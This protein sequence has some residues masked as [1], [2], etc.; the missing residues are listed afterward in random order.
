M[1][2]APPLTLLLQGSALPPALSPARADSL[3]ATIDSVFAAPAYRWEA[4]EDPFGALRRLWGGLLRWVDELQR[5]NPATFNAVVWALVGVLALILAHAGWVALRTLRHGS[6]QAQRETAGP[7]SAP[8][9]ATWY[10]RESA[11]LAALGD[12]A[13]AMQAEFLRL[14][15]ELDARQVMRFHPSKTPNEYVRDASLTEDGR[16]DMRGLVREMYHYAF[17]RAPLDGLAFDR[18]RALAVA[19]R[20]RR[21]T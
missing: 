8:R 9:D 15:L 6:R 12:Y 11:R 16:R 20:F 21:V 3:R 17:A 4:R 14:V 19:D 2:I 7:A 10:T 13:G 1:P 18:W 5:T